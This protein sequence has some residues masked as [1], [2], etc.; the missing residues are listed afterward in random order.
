MSVLDILPI[1]DL[2]DQDLER[3]V[4]ELGQSVVV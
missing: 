3:T 1:E 4:L 2:L